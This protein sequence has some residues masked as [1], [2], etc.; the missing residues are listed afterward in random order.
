MYMINYRRY[1]VQLLTISVMYMLDMIKDLDILHSPSAARA[2]TQVLAPVPTQISLL[3]L[4]LI[5][6]MLVL[7]VLI[8][9]SVRSA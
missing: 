7:F 2:I 1:S 6:M 9:V 5:T 8:M 3:L 4:V